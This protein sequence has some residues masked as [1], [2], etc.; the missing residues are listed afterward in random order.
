M[1]LGDAKHR[2]YN[3]EFEDKTSVSSGPIYRDVQIELQSHSVCQ[4]IDTIYFFKT[5]SL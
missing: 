5:C 3:P 1:L 4:D 2:L